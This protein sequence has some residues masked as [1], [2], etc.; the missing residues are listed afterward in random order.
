VEE[1]RSA[2]LHSLS[3]FFGTAALSPL[4]YA[5]KNWNEESYNGGC[6]V[7]VGTPGMM[8]GM[9]AALRDPFQR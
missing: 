3:E 1:R 4:D 8:T 5:E 9:A 6:P 7:C 2:V